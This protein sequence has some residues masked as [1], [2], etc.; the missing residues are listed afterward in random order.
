MCTRCA[1]FCTPQSVGEVPQLKHVQQRIRPR[2][3]V[4]HEGSCMKGRRINEHPFSRSAVSETSGA[5][6]IC[7][8]RI[9][10]FLAA[11]AALDFT[12]LVSQLV[13]SFVSQLHYFDILQR[14]T[15]ILWHLVSGDKNLESG[16]Q[17]KIEMWHLV[18]EGYEDEKS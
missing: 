9:Y 10:I 15:C 14:M 5:Q 11:K 3:I 16:T 2:G 17:K 13:C 7:Y 18:L 4:G 6:L 1:R 12:L 8:V